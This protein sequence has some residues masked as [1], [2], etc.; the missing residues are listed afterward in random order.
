MSREELL[1]QHD[2]ETSA[3][4]ATS[5]SFDPNEDSLLDELER[6]GAPPQ[7]QFTGVDDIITENEHLLAEKYVSIT[8]AMHDLSFLQI[9][10]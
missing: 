10:M 8:H 2:L 3:T 7:L 1:N 5:F 4:G 6:A 9:M